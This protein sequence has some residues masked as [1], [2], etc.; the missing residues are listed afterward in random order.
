[1]FP[2]Q[3][4]FFVQGSSTPEP[5]EVFMLKKTVFAFVATAA[6]AFAPASADARGFRHG[7]HGGGWHGGVGPAVVGGLIAG[8]ALGAAASS[9]YAYDPGYTYYEGYYPAPAYGYSYGYYG[10]GNCPE[11]GHGAYYNCGR[12]AVP[13]YGP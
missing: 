10:A 6:I 7:F 8:A 1:V 13:G 9:A 12:Y 4:R 5:R 2:S 11:P 3:A